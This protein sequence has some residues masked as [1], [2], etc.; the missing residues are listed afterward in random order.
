M[1]IATEI[2]AKTKWCPF[3]R[4][5]QWGRGGFFID[6]RGIQPT[7]AS[8]MRCI[9]SQCMAWK[10]HGWVGETERAGFCGLVRP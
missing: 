3:V 9:G 2:E 10:W 1:T 4:I 5:V 6:N 7:A 8:D